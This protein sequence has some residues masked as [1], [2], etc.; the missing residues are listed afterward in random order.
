MEPMRI[1]ATAVSATFCCT[2]RFCM[3]AMSPRAVPSEPDVSA[4][5]PRMLAIVSRLRSNSEVMSMATCSVSETI[6]RAPRMRSF[7]SLAFAAA[8]RRRPRSLAPAASGFSV[9]SPS[10]FCRSRP[11]RAFSSRPASALTESRSAPCF[12][13]SAG[14]SA[15]LADRTS[16][17]NCFARSPADASSVAASLANFSPASTEPAASKEET[18]LSP[19]ARMSSSSAAYSWNIVVRACFR[20]EQRRLLFLSPS[21]ACGGCY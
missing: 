12:S 13:R 15:A 18:A 2:S 3:P 1:A 7:C 5:C 4:T 11:S 10:R 21:G 9:E 8:F 14:F 6:S 20:T 19:L 17:S 16:T